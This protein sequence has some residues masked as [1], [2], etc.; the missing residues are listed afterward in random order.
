MKKLLGLLI[1]LVLAVTVSIGIAAQ[2][3]E[4]TPVEESLGTY[5]EEAM[6]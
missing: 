3:A 2:S 6:E 5:Y 1:V 4:D